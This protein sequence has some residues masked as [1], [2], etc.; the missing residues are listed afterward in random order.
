M[1]DVPQ[2]QFL[3]GLQRV[4]IQS[5]ASKT[6]TIPRLK[7]SVWRCNWQWR[8]STET[9]KIDRYDFDAAGCKGITYVFSIHCSD[10]CKKPTGSFSVLLVKCSL[11]TY[12]HYKE[13]HLT[14]HHFIL[15]YFILFSSIWCHETIRQLTVTQSQCLRMKYTANLSALK[16]ET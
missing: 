9:S 16:R 6:V 12:M 10:V 4:W 1:Q 8:D 11:E 14:T 5:F 3:S 15:F 7:S 2:S 13:I